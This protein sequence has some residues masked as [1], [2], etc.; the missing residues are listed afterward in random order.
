MTKYTTIF[1]AIMIILGTSNCCFSEQ[2]K[3]LSENA[4][5]TANTIN[6]NV[7]LR[8]RNALKLT[9]E[10]ENEIENMLREIEN[11]KNE[12]E[13]IKIMMHTAINLSTIIEMSVNNAITHINNRFGTNKSTNLIQCLGNYTVIIKFIAK[14]LQEIKQNKREDYSNDDLI[15]IKELLEDY[16]NCL[17]N[18]I[19]IFEINGE[20]LLI[21]ISRKDKQKAQE[22]LSRECLIFEVWLSI[23]INSGANKNITMP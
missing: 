13:H 9:E 21:N 16:K 23:F 4:N 18:I 3:H 11:A 15:N 10:Q 5:T 1:S 8:R 19:N 12:E 7:T 17:N 20:T 6:N 22:I 14:Q 2:P